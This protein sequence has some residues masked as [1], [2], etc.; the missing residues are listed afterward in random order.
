LPLLGSGLGVID[1]QP[2]LFA[3]TTLNLLGFAFGC[4]AAAIVA[5][6]RKLAGWISM[7]ALANVG[8]W[9]SLQTTTPDAFAFG[10]MLLG[11]ASAIRGRSGLAG[12]LLAGAI[13]TKETYAVVGVSMIAWAIAQRDRKAAA[14]YSMA[15][16]PAIA[17]SI[18]LAITL[19][20]GLATGGNLGMPFV[21]LV[22]AV[23]VWPGTGLR[24]QVLTG[25]TLAVLALSVFVI[26][27]RGTGIWLFLLVPWVLLA[28]ISSH[29]IWDLG[30]NSIRSLAPLL[31]FSLFGLNEQHRSAQPSNSLRNLPV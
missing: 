21:G 19:R 7:A 20:E 24:D 12:L 23:A 27:R 14:R 8:I 18:Y 1:G 25:L 5:D 30:N 11:V 2:L 6:G 22:E 16:L 17:W 28:L 29:W 15:L 13:L 26:A 10:L 31:T 3:L 9:L 4:W